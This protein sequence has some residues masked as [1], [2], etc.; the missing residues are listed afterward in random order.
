M[1]LFHGHIF[2]PIFYQLFRLC[3]KPFILLFLYFQLQIYG[4]Y[5]FVF[6]ANDF[7]QFF[8][9]LLEHSHFF[10]QVGHLALILIILN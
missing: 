6:L 1:F 4:F 5:L 9:F 3:V 8:G 7:I 2:V 10:D